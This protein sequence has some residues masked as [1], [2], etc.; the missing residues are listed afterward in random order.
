VVSVLIKTRYELWFCP[1]GPRCCST[2]SEKNREP[3][4]HS[5]S[6]LAVDDVVTRRAQKFLGFGCW[7]AYIE[8]TRLS[9]GTPAARCFDTPLMRLP[10]ATRVKTSP[11]LKEVVPDATPVVV[12]ETTSVRPYI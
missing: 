7:L 1:L 12:P 3:P 11:E 4:L 9:T 6:R 8:A 5:R 10:C 2:L